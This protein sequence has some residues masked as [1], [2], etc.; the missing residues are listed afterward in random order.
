MRLFLF[1]AAF[2][3]VP[4]SASAGPKEDAL[5]VLDRWTEAFAASD[6]DTLVNLHAPDALF[7]GTGSK[8]VVCHPTGRHQ[9]ILR[10]CGAHPTPKGSTIRSRHVSVARLR[11]DAYF[12][13]YQLN[14]HAIQKAFSDPD[15]LASDRRARGR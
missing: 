7:M 13:F 3:L 10:R 15:L 11:G 6:V 4:W 9:K 5:Q 2:A 12:I 14:G 8:T 1:A